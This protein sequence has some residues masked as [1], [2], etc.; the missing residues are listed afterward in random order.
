MRRHLLAVLLM[1]LASPVARSEEPRLVSVVKIWD[2]AR[3]SAFTDLIRWHGRWYCV[4]REAEAHVGGDGKLRVLESADGSG[5]EPVGLV[6][7]DGIDL[8]DPHLSITPDDRLMVVAGGSVYRGGTKLLGRQPR[9]SF[10]KDARAWTAP[11]RVLS[12]GD[13][14]WRVTW[15]DGK[16]YG[17]TYDANQTDWKLRLVVSSDGVKFERITEFDIPG[18]PNETTLRFLP[19]GEMMALVRREGGDTFGW[20]GSSKSPYRDWSWQPTKHR[21]GGP[22]FLR[23][24][25]RRWWAV[26]RSYP[27]GAKTALA[28][29]SRD[30]YEPVLMLPS[31][32]DTSYAGLVWH[33]GLLWISYYSSHEG[34]SSIYLAK[35]KLPEVVHDIGTRLELF[36]DDALISSLSGAAERKLHQPVP[37]E[38]V[39]VADQPWEGNTSAYYTLFQ[40]RDL[41]RMYYRGAHF[42]EKVKKPAHREVTCYAESKDG[43]HW[44]RPSLGLFEFDGRRDNNIIWDGPGTHNFT[45][46]KDAN[47]KASPD[48]RYKALATGKGGLHAFKSADGIH[49]S[50]LTEGPVITQG[51]FDSQNLAFWDAGLGKYRDYHRAFLGGVRCIMTCTSD[52]FVTWTPPVFL[53]YPDAPLEHLYTNAIRPYERA[54]HL[55][56]GFPTRFLPA[57]QQVEPTFMASRDG[58]TFRR[59]LQPVIPRTAPADREGNRSNYMASGLLQL[60]HSDRELS[61]YGTEAYYAGPG[62]RLRRFSYRVDGFTSISAPAQGG[63]LTTT[64]LRFQGGRLI[65]NYLTRPG[66]SVR[67]ELQDESGKALEG[68]TLAD[69]VALQGDAIVQTAAWK[70]IGDVGRLHER[71]VR[72]HFELKDAELFSF[73]FQ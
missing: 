66:G 42:D 15:H 27:G 58:L 59:W 17:V 25:D 68:Y 26:S 39:L 16:A 67:V 69:C 61:V 11:A 60:P 8:R 38:V 2:K 36:V 54:P 9:V 32:G 4:F 6:E 44:T 72:L 64:P 5:W 28:R 45:P 19:G 53:E 71:P 10:S 52:D 63:A 30:S 65:L 43:I 37:R 33:E 34:K 35:V 55:L 1:T 48:A 12:E 3:H 50:P 7:E 62:S 23:L 41:Y 73:R 13:W 51:A 21:F 22:N 70:S 14:L 40:D 31:G 49:W 29:M 57:Q 24:P 18:R 20:I 46:F 47:P 56:L